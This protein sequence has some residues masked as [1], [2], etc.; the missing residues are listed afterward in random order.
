MCLYHWIHP[1]WAF[2][3]QGS[4]LLIYIWT[5]QFIKR[6][7]T[8]D[9]ECQP[10]FGS[11]VDA[12]SSWYGFD[13][14]NNNHLFDLQHLLLWRFWLSFE[15]LLPYSLLWPC[16]LMELPSILWFQR[17]ANDL[18][19]SANLVL[20]TVCPVSDWSRVGYEAQSDQW[21]TIL[22]G[23]EELLPPSHLFLWAESGSRW[24][25]SR[26]DRGWS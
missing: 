20:L 13:N 5:H 17:W 9:H 19:I 26:G 16:G 11:E 12:P 10:D 21:N 8:V 1:S 22:G 14:N 2:S 6:G 4:M 25:L 15:D 3:I 7:K 24:A 23:H 18:H